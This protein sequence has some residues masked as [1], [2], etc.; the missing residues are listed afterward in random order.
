MTQHKR[1][2]FYI[3]YGCGGK[4]RMAL[5]YRR[6]QERR[7]AESGASYRRNTIFSRFDSFY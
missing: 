4:I 3:Q 6:K 5:R 1:Y 7:G 2:G